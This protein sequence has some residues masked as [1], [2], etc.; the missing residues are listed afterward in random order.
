MKIT[1]F[2]LLFVMF[3][4]YCGNSYS[5][6]A[7][8]SIPNA[9]LRVGQVLEQIESQTEYLFVY[10]K[11]NVDVR[12]TVDIDANN[13]TVSEVLDRMFEGTDIKYV[14]EGKNIVLTKNSKSAGDK[15]EFLQEMATVRGKVTDSKGEPIIGVNILE[16]GTANGVITNAEGFFSINIP[17]N[18]T[19]TVS[20]MGY[21]PQ[22]IAVSGRPSLLI[23]MKEETLELEQVVVTAMGIQKKISSLTYATQQISGNELTRA[24]EPNMINALAGKTAGVQFNKTANLGGSAKV[25][26]RGARSAFAGGNNQPLYVIDGVPMLNSSTESTSTVIGGNYDGLN[27][28]AGDGISNL[29]PDDIESINI[30][31][32]ASA[33]ALYGSQ[34]ANGVILITTRKGKAGV[35]RVTFSSNLTV[36]HAI[37]TPEFQNTYGRNEDGGTASWGPKGNLT[38]YD[39]LGEFF[40]NGVTAIN[41]LAITSGN[42]KVQ[43][44]FSY[45]NTT[46]KGIVDNNRL[47]KNNLS[48]HETVCLFNSRLKL[49]GIATLM[50]QTVKNSPATGGYYLNP[51]V[52]L[53]SF[54]RGVDMSPYKENFEIWNADRNMMVQNWIE[55]N[56]DG[57]ISEWGQNSYWLRNRVLNSNKRY[58]AVVSVN[59][60]LQVTKHFSLQARGNVDYISDKFENKMYATTAP[61]IAGRYE[62]KENG[63]YIWSDNQEIQTYGDVMALFN[64]EF[65]NFSLNTALGASI[66]MSKVNSLNMDSRLASLYKPNVFTVP[67]I[68]MDSKAAVNQNIDTKRTLQSVFA[69]M[70]LGWKELLYLDITAR[71]DWSSTL[72]YTDSKKSGF[73][74]PSTG[75]TWILNKTFP[76]PKW[77]SLA[78]IRASW[79]EVGNDLPIGITNPVDIIM[80]GGSV[81]VNNVEQRG[82]LK[83]EISSSVEFGTEWRF[84]HHRFG[85]DFTWY[86]TNTKNQLLRMNNPTG[87]SYKYRYVNAGKIRNQGF[88]LTIDVTPLLYENF[89][90][91]SLINMSANKN[92]VVA[93][94]PEYTEF[95]YYDEGFNAGYQMRVKEGGRLGDIYGNAF[96]RDK[97][98]KIMVDETNKRPLGN[99]GNKDLLGNFNP[100]FTMGWSNTLTYKNI[101]VYFLTDFRFGG[102]V[103]S[104]T[105]SEMDANGVTKVTAEA[106]NRG[107]VEYQGQ[108]FND[109]RAFYSAVGGRNAISEYYMYNATCIRLREVSLSYSLPKSVLGNGKFIKGIDVSLVVRNL[110]FFKKEAPFDPDIVMSVG[111]NNQGVDVFGM[112]MTR[113]IGFNLKFTF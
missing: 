107:Y 54:P 55:K 62:G 92:K 87:S 74:Y 57:T 77:I 109:P 11:K 42:D 80:A 88:E 43:T 89:S 97:N 94:H 5:Q 103:M 100:D 32:G 82:D 17:P 7:K 81:N 95:S 66:N 112:P 4:V 12:R 20:Y 102:K 61:N 35:Q 45:A 99:T 70:Q 105:Q 38:K 76:L 40:G 108:T 51:L 48:L 84:F 23:R 106:R 2:L 69:T 90:W 68:V 72:A 30:L 104:L 59:A 37:S 101:E 73:F 65:N 18:A 50:T 29:N 113:N 98:G 78:K 47:Q 16:K 67:N 52:S 56:G 63:R 14:M 53:Y 36:A 3:Q 49:N 96:L 44:Y 10:N 27:R 83:P 8:V 58:R 75:A 28:D 41:S 22:T 85:I 34:A 15:T 91:K 13:K 39:N 24:K 71:N 60:N 21:E 19:I 25:A 79:A 110:C 46:A 64:K 26:I 9:R 1:L 86:R 111:N 93:L 33:A 6:N 31:K